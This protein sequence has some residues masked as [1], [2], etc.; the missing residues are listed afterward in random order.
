MSTIG[1][2]R[3]TSKMSI[4]RICEAPSNQA[5][6]R[7]ARRPRKQRGLELAHVWRGFVERPIP[8]C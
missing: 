1:S 7:R 8:L 6:G 2:L 3:S 4:C 5:F